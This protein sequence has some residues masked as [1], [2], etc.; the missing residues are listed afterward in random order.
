[1]EEEKASLISTD[2]CFWMHKNLEHLPRSVRWLVSWLLILSDF[3]CVGVFGPLQSA[4][5][6]VDPDYRRPRDM[7]YFL[8]AKTNSFQTSISKVYLFSVCSKEY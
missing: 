8:K 6:P 2:L 3:H 4:R 5:A 7:I 1:M